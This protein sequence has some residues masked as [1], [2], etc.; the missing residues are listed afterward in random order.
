MNGD[1]VDVKIKDLAANPSPLGLMGFGMT[2]VL[3]NLHNAGYFSLGAVILS[4]GFFYGGLAQVIAGIEE[5][6]KGN[7]LCIRRR[8]SIH[9]RLYGRDCKESVSWEYRL[10]WLYLLLYSR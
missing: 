8:L 2:T 3:L 10:L 7:T 5:W 4:M 9:F 1:V 6:K